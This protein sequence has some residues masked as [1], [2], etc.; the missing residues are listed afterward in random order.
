M[1]GEPIK[2][3]S[4]PQVLLAVAAF[5]I[6]WMGGQIATDRAMPLSPGGGSLFV[7]IFGGPFLQGFETPLLSHFVIGLLIAAAMAISLLKRNVIQLPNLKL[8][9][10][11]VGFFG[12]LFVSVGISEFRFFSMAALSEWL[13]YAL[14]FF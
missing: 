9:G 2:R 10:L 6:P 5:L 8:A 12:L 4:A 13:L 1:A 14:A 11:F 3:L 7:S